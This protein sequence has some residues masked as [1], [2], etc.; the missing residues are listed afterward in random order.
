MK[1][2]ILFF[3]ILLVQGCNEHSSVESTLITQPD[4]Y[5]GAWEKEIVISVLANDEYPA[6]AQLSIKSQPER[7]AVRVVGSEIHYIPPRE[8]V[9]V[10][11]EYSVSAQNGKAQT[12]TVSVTLHNAIDLA[13]VTQ[14]EDGILVEGNNYSVYI[15]TRVP[16]TTHTLFLRREVLQDVD[17]QFGTNQ[18][19]VDP[20][21]DGYQFEY[22]P[23]DLVFEF[24]GNEIEHSL[25]I[26][27]DEDLFNNAY[28]L[29]YVLLNTPTAEKVPSSFRAT[30]YNEPGARAIVD[31]RA[32]ALSWTSFPVWEIPMQPS[33]YEDP[34]GNSTWLLYYHSLAWL[35]A[36]EYR[37][38]QS[39][40]EKVLQKIRSYINSYID[41]V[42]I[43]RKINMTW[44]DHTVAAR[45]GT[46]AYFYHKFFRNNLT[47]QEESNW[48]TY[49]GAHADRLYKYFSDKR[50]YG[51]NHGLIHATTLYKISFIVPEIIGMQAYREAS[52]KRMK[53]LFEEMVTVETGASKEQSMHY[54]L[55][56][57]EMLSGV[58]R[59]EQSLQ[60]TTTPEVL[61]YLRV[62]VD[63]TAHLIYLNGGGPSFGDSNYAATNYLSRLKKLVEKSGISTP[64]YTYLASAGREGAT[65][66]RQY[67]GAEDGY[68]VTRFIDESN[69]YAEDSAYM[70]SSFGKK[71]FSH[72]HHDATNVV[73]AVNGRSILVDSGGPYLY[74][75]AGRRYFRSKYAH[76]TLVINGE[77]GFGNDAEL[78]GNECVESMCVVYG[79]IQDAGVEQ[80]RL[81]AV[82]IQD[83]TPHLYVFDSVVELD[84]ESTPS[85]SS[86]ELLYHFSPTSVLETSPRDNCYTITTEDRGSWCMSFESSHPQT[87]TVKKGILTEVE[88][89]GW[90][91]PKFGSKVPAPV[92]SV[93]SEGASEY[94]Q[95]TSLV[96]A[97]S[98]KEQGRVNRLNNGYSLELG[99]YRIDLTDTHSIQPQLV[100]NKIN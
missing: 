31:N 58:K 25:V 99:D 14:S 21:G 46:L 49:I 67:S 20:V 63:F 42:G 97:P 55:V 36:Y 12:E 11:F 80:F 48:L 86:F 96:P 47:E 6:D 10:S 74:T 24:Y 37:Y 81:Q 78:L 22:Q 89:Q 56:A 95:L 52:S 72:G 39:K 64:Y 4:I 82:S 27:T 68:V 7:G 88:E 100:I 28:K 29:D 1:R 53:E 3:L 5:S 79:R 98:L 32:F 15:E 54:Q 90:V 8:V 38:E 33:W 70:L 35:H 71:F 91:Q 76:N 83:K 17:S 92:F 62:M 23:T 61:E 43:D 93:I 34:Y 16:L 77:Q 75:S 57:L 84:D 41:T 60:G 85:S 40:D 26:A 87:V 13:Q 65:L 44:N 45:A 66:E 18:I 94:F 2:A 69:D 50:F 9:D 19:M 73:F 30:W 59:L 51:H